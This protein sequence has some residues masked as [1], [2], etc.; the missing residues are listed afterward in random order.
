VHNDIRAEGRGRSVQR[1]HKKIKIWKCSH[2]S[3]VTISACTWMCT[4]MCT[5]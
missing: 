3:R 4:N 2:G 1:Q 5:N